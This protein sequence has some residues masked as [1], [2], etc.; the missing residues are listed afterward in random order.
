MRLAP[1]PL[2][3]ACVLLLGSSAVHAQQIISEGGQPVEGQQQQQQQVPVQEQQP[4]MEGTP[5]QQQPIMEGGQEVQPVQ[6][7]EERLAR[8]ISG[9]ISVPFFLTDGTIVDDPVQSIDAGAGIGLHG[10]FGWELGFIVLE[11]QVGWQLQSLS[12]TDSTLQDIWIGLGARFQ[13]LNR[14]RMVPFVSAA[15]RLNIWSERV[16]TGGSSVVGEYD[17]DPGAQVGLGL[18][19]EITR[20]FGIEAAVSSNFVFGISDT[21]RDFQFFLQ[22]WIGA[23]LFI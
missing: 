1:R 6:Q 8:Q 10:R 21:F 5:V 11:G 2:S 9:Y 3:L 22:P 4:I 7:Q 14:S 18:T 12:G 17:F 15:L 23:T 13:L 20:S 16:N 19:I